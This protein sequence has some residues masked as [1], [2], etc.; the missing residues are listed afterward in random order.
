M[1]FFIDSMEFVDKSNAVSF[2]VKALDYKNCTKTK[3]S[4]RRVTIWWTK[5]NFPLCNARTR[6]NV[7]RKIIWKEIWIPERG[8]FLHLKEEEKV[9]KH[10]TISWS[11]K[12]AMFPK[13]AVIFWDIPWQRLI[14]PAT[15]LLPS[16]EGHVRRKK[17][18]K[19]G[20]VGKII[21]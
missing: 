11:L 19:S 8:V 2:T 13:S 9:S 3:Q 6:V 21:H 20:V 18:K 7:M 10:I 17:Q 5:D 4:L 16:C 14:S 1:E 15:L 12:V